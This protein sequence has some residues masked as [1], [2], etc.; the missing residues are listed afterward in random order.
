MQL[1]EVVARTGCSEAALREWVREGVI[2]PFHSI[3]G[4]GNHSVY[5]GA[6]V[7]AVAV[8]RELKAL[9]IVPKRVR[10][11]FQRL[12][13]LLRSRSSLEW[14]GARVIMTRENVVFEGDLPADADPAAI[15]LVL[16]LDR[17]ARSLVPL[18]SDPQLSLPFGVAAVR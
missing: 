15:T 2:V 6:N 1:A 7:I 16:D 14:R 9:G 4:S 11:Q 5:D 3:P 13:V 8:V 17:M 18:D 10:E 12:H